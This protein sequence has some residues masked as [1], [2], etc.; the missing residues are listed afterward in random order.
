MTTS[1]GVRTF[2]LFH[3]TLIHRTLDLRFF[4]WY[5]II[6]QDNWHISH[7]W[8]TFNQ[9]SQH[10]ILIGIRR[11]I[12]QIHFQSIVLLHWPTCYLVIDMRASHFP[13]KY[14][15]SLG[16]LGFFGMNCRLPINLRLCSLPTRVKLC[17]EKSS[18][19]I[20]HHLVVAHAELNKLFYYLELDFFQFQLKTWYVRGD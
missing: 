20:D 18:H 12:D 10:Q 2:S 8:S 16:W 13:K 7:A 19:S 6:E 9:I 5:Y 17:L 3:L 15:W 14:S 1:V 11:L 4:C